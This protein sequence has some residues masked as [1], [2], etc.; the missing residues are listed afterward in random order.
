MYSFLTEGQHMIT[1]R[2]R[3]TGKARRVRYW[4]DDTIRQVLA[5]QKPNEDVF[6][7]KYPKN[8]LLRF[9]ILDFDSKEDKD[10]VYKE[11]YQLKKQLNKHGHNVVVVDSTNK[12]LHLYIEI[13][14]V[15]FKDNGNWHV[16]DW[17]SFFRNFQ[18]Y[19]IRRSSTKSHLVEYKTLDG[20]NSKAGLNGNIRLVGSI[21]PSTGETVNIIDGSFKDLQVPTKFQE[22][23]MRIAL[24]MC[25]IIHERDEYNKSQLKTTV[26]NG[27]DPIQNNDL[28]EVFREITGDI[29]VYNKGYAYCCCP[30]HNDNHPSMLVTK[31]WYSCSSCNAKGNIWTLKKHGLVD[32]DTD[33]RVK[34]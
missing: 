1:V 18:E 9:L 19:F 32:F 31:E 26:V 11:V 7:Q 10:L 21:H 33:G 34:I 20:I 6:V 13:A 27:N 2:N 22:K 23:C 15:L 29:K 12:G 30:F 14:P 28:R 17:N 24:S 25:E 3:D 16:S 4:N 5:N 8:R